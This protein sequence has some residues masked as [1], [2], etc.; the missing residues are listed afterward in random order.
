MYQNDRQTDLGC[1]WLARILP[2]DACFA[3]YRHDTPWLGHRITWEPNYA[4]AKIGDRLTL[5]LE[6]NPCMLQWSVSNND[7]GSGV[8]LTGNQNRSY[9]LPDLVDLLNLSLR[10]L[11]NDSTMILSLHG[12]YSPEGDW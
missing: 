8:S 1:D 2:Y 3:R 7:S 6:F 9:P 5:T 11:C 4:L 10:E 12:R